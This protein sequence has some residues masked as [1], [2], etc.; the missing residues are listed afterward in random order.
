MKIFASKAPWYQA[1]LAFECRACGRCCAGPEEGFVWATRE[2]IAKIARFLGISEA[3]MHRKYVRKVGRRFSLMEKRPSKDCVFLTPREDG[4]KGCSIYAVRP[5]QCR[6]WPFWSGNLGS[7]DSWAAAGM[8]CAGI[9]RGHLFDFE[10]IE[11]RRQA[12]R[13]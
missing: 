9:N 11:S 4:S 10:E 3:E 5:T 6:T 8:R 2:E 7:P 13:E 1:G 12:T